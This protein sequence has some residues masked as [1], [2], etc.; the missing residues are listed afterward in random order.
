AGTPVPITLSSAGTGTLTLRPAIQY[1]KTPDT[2][3]IQVFRK[4]NLNQ[5]LESK[6]CSKVA[7]AKDGYGRNMYVGDVFESSVYIS[8]VDNLLVSDTT[9]N[10]SITPVYLVGGSDGSPATDGECIQAISSLSN[11]DIPLTLVIDGG[12]ATVDYQQA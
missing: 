7:G 5:P 6:V 1:T 3:V 10:D 8:I 4:S 11:T 9:V 12:R 2:F